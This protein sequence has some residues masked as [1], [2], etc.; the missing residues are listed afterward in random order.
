MS[1][2]T[3]SNDD[4]LQLKSVLSQAAPAGVNLAA[5][6]PAPASHHDFCSIWPAAV[7]VLTLISGVVAA[8]PGAGTTASAII[9]GLI[10]A[11][12]E[13]NKQICK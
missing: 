1:A 12:N 8:I 11:G 3:L 9:T 4:L 6:A 10:A 13:V 5:A 2:P 7:P